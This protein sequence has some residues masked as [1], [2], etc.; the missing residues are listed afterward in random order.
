[1]SRHHY[2]HTHDST[3]LAGHEAGAHRALLGI[4]FVLGTVVGAYGCIAVKAMA[5]VS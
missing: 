4:F 2:D 3:E 5:V 1:M